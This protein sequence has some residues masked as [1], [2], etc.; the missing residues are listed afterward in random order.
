[1][2]DKLGEEGRWREAERNGLTARDKA[3]KAR[4]GSARMG[5]QGSTA[6]DKM[7]AGERCS[8]SWYCFEVYRPSV[9]SVRAPLSRSSYA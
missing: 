8:R 2:S 9:E 4:G 1:M 7:D 3:V 6:D 5:L